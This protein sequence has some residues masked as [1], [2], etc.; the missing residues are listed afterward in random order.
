MLAM[1]MLG[2]DKPDIEALLRT[3][4]SGGQSLPVQNDNDT[5]APLQPTLAEFARAVI[6]AAKSP[7]VARFHSDR[8][9]IGSI[10]EHMRGARPIFDMSLEEFKHKLVQAHRAR[11]LR[12]TRADLVAAMDPREVERSEARYQDATFHFVALDAGGM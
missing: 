11:L 4:L 2:A 7:K 6:E 10:W 1:R 3:L 5:K 12:I 9:F 8:A